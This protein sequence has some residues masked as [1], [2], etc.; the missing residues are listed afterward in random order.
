MHHV[1]I[2]ISTTVSELKVI[3]FSKKCKIKKGMSSSKYDNIY[4]KLHR[5]S[6]QVFLV[7]QSTE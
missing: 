7:S 4:D 6:M 1:C 5:L 3:V 2:N